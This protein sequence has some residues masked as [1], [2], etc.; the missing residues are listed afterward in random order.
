MGTLA[1]LSRATSTD[2]STMSSERRPQFLVGFLRGNEPSPMFHTNAVQVVI[3][4]MVR[5]AS[6]SRIRRRCSPMAWLAMSATRSAPVDR[7]DLLVLD[8][9]PDAFVGQSRRQL[10]VQ[11][12]PP[13][14]E[15]CLVGGN[16]APSEAPDEVLME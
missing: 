3:R 2:R 7:S 10:R 8:P 11:R 16:L 1:S 9:E 14:R 4:W 6:C 15:A 12:E 13:R 5:R